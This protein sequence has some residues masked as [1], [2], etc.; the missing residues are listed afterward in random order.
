MKYIDREMSGDALFDRAQM[1][2][3]QLPESN[4]MRFSW[5]LANISTIIREVK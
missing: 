5:E 3:E 4:T 2:S 1:K